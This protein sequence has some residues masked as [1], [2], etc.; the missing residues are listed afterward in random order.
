MGGKI[1]KAGKVV[2]LLGGRYAGRK[3]VIVKPSDEGNNDKPFSHALV[4]G[5]DRYPRKVTKKMSKKKVASRS[6]VKP[7][8]KVV[9]YNHMVRTKF[10]ERYKSGKNRWFFQKLKF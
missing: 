6:K 4:A 8:I 3:A 1:M 10:E 9:N 7:F 2:L 5:I